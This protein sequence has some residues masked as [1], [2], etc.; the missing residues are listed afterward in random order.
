MSGD[1]GSGVGIVVVDEGFDIEPLL[2]GC[3]RSFDPRSELDLQAVEESFFWHDLLR[4]LLVEEFHPRKF[5]ELLTIEPDPELGIKL[6][7]G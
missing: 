5:P 3:W 4:E 1:N 7:P 2:W 6:P